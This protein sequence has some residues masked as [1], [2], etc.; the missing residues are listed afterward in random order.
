MGAEINFADYS[1]KKRSVESYSDANSEN[2]PGEQHQRNSAFLGIGIIH[3][4][5]Y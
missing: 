1:V 2:M 5:S 4:Q 3:V